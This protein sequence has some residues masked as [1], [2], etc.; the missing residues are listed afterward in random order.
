MNKR[1][2]VLFLAGALCAA[3]GALAA[4]ASGGALRRFVVIAGANYGGSDRVPLRYAVTDGENFG[5][6]LEE[7]GGV[8]A[9]DLTLLREP[10][11]DRLKGALREVRE[12]VGAAPRQG[13]TE[14]VLYYSG[15]AD[16]KGLLLGDERFPYQELRREMKSIPT[17]VRITVLD[18][19]ES[20][21]ITRLKG[22][23]RYESFLID[24]SMDMEGYAFITSSSEDEAA[25]ESDRINGSFFTHY[26]VSGLRGAADVTGDGRVTLSEAY[27]FAFSET[28]TRTAGTQGGAQHPAYDINLT[29]TGDVV[30]TDVRETSAGVVLGEGLHGRFFIRNANEQLVAELFK[31]AGRSV[32][33]GLEPGRYVVHVERQENLRT[34]EL[35]LQEG[36]RLTIQEADLVE[37]GRE[38]TALRGGSGGGIPMELSD[39]YDFFTYGEGYSLSI[40]V[41]LNRKRTPFHGLQ[42]ALL[43]TNSKRSTASQAAGI[44]N[45][46]QGSVSGLQLS[47]F[48]NHA[49]GSVGKAQLGFANIAEE[50]VGF[51]QFAGGVNYAGART[52]AQ[53]AGFANFA[54]KEIG[55]AQLSSGVNYAGGGVGRLQGA[56]LLNFADSVGF[57]QLAG[58]VNYI[59]SRR[60]TQ[61]QAAVF[62]NLTRGDVGVGQGTLG[63]NFAE[64]DVSFA[65]LAGVG[66]ATVGDLTGVQLANI[67]NYAGEL[68]GAQGALGLNVARRVNGLQAG[69]VNVARTVEGAQIGLVNISETIEGPSIGLFTYSKNGLFNLNVWGDETGLYHLTASTGSRSVFT[70]LSAGYMPQDSKRAYSFGLG[71]GMHFARDSDFLEVDIN[72]YVVVDEFDDSDQDQNFNNLSRLR[73]SLGHEAVPGM[74][75]FGGISCNLLWIGEDSQLTRPVGDYEIE[76]GDEYRGWVG[77]HAGMRMGR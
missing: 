22:G 26:L 47:A 77:F 42:V 39:Q 37:A 15:H 38:R 68:H 8:E 56:G 67:A 36:Q 11:P 40:S 53:Y 45:L 16:E 1:S 66:N 9:G 28:L 17:D 35:S 62:A 74:A 2:A 72:N 48:L 50:S 31:P 7:M 54:R 30:M 69:A 4:T 55:F 12:R 59:G 71:T 20:G 27:Q 63:L 21:A 34:S 41:L 52:E 51:G 60:E 14:V 33:L 18:A 76:I 70:S 61:L 43:V 5:K 73:A 49:S 25:Q 64:G 44:A 65:Q 23:R 19:C 10:G 57:G 46:A 3:D 13:R 75:F 6:V 58:G 24:D 29:G 32:E